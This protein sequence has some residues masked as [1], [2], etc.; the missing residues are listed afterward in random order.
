MCVDGCV[1]VYACVCVCKCVMYTDVGVCAYECV[2]VCVRVCKQAL[3]TSGCYVTLSNLVQLYISRAFSCSADKRSCFQTIVPST[4]QSDIRRT[5]DY[6]NPRRHNA[7]T[8]TQT[9][10]NLPSAIRGHSDYRKG[11]RGHLHICVIFLSFFSAFFSH[12]ENKNKT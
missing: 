3:Q 2:C 1:H 7:Q 8:H 5:Q 12:A 11:K 9:P 10:Q 6:D 4:R